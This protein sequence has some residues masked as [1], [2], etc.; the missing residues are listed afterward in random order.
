MTARLFK[1]LR[2][3]RRPS[4]IVAIFGHGFGDNKNNS[5]FI[6]VQL[7]GRV[8]QCDAPFSA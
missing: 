4:R 3:M 8:T 7:K 5:P 1:L 2:P 6:D